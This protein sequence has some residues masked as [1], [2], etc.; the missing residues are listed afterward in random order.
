M[1]YSKKN[2]YL[3]KILVVI[4]LSFS[5]TNA[6]EINKIT[7]EKIKIEALYN[8]F[9]YIFK[10]E[11]NN[12]DYI[13]VYLIPDINLWKTQTQNQK[14]LRVNKYL[15]YKIT[16]KKNILLEL[17]N[18]YG[19]SRIEKIDFKYQNSINWTRNTSDFILLS[20]EDFEIY[21]IEIKIKV[22]LE[23]VSTELKRIILEP[24]YNSSYSYFAFDNSLK[25]YK[26]SK[27]LFFDNNEKKLT[28]FI[29]KNEPKITFFKPNKKN[30]LEFTFLIS[31]IIFII[32]INFFFKIL[33]NSIFIFI[34]F[35]FQNYIM[36][37]FLIINYIILY[38]FIYFLLFTFTLLLLGNFF[39][40]VP[41]N[42]SFIIQNLE[43]NY[44]QLFSQI[45]I[46]QFLFYLFIATYFYFKFHDKKN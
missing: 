20:H 11:L 37:F 30:L 3:V 41:T 26:S 19:E 38:N 36:I 27:N 43:Y 40:H 35:Y 22:R 44:L 15:D 2:N 14:H 5:D 16:S 21:P 18:E 10:S 17:K 7:D 6:Y 45:N 42:F 24:Y 23:N 13:I 1:L 8:N 4:L 32:K 25:I 12:K 28:N 39:F 31:I 9:Y 33:I 34:S 29:N 46:G